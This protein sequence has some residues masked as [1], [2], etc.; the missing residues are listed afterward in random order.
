MLNKFDMLYGHTQFLIKYH[1]LHK[2]TLKESSSSEKRNKKF[3][4]TCLKRYGVD[5][6]SQI[7]EVKEKKKKT[8]LKNYGV[9]NIWKSK[10]YY[11]WLDN[12]M[13]E[14]Y[15][16]KRIGGSTEARSD[17]AKKMWKSFD[18]DFK[19]YKIA[20]IL[21]NLHSGKTSKI[22]I[23]IKTYLDFMGIEHQHSFWIKRNQFD[24][25]IIDSNILIEIH[26]DFW[27]ANPNKYKPD[28]LLNFPGQPQKRA[29]DIWEKDKKKKEFAKSK[30]YDIIT[31]WEDFINKGTREE[32]LK[33]VFKE[34]KKYNKD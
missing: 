8:F 30:G 18:P 33:Y 27:H 21:K 9:D 25:K 22:E 4:S 13:L 16:K 6:I 15:N 3:K 14:K 2:R 12:F 10:D 20:E 31:I 1:N 24:F 23:K 17:I 34:I 28:D 7:T 26:G 11:E 32:V 5:N 19:K 29:S